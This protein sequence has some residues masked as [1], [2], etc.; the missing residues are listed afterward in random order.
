LVQNSV[1][2]LSDAGVLTGLTGLTSSGSVTLSGLTSGRVPYASTGGLLADSANLLYSGTD[3]TVYGL[4]VGRGA[5]AVSTNTAVGASALAANTSGANNTGIGNNAL[6]SNTTGN[7][8][9]SVGRSALGSITTASDNSALGYFALQSNSTGA[10]NTAVGVSAL[11]ENTTGSNNTAL[12]YQA[13]YTQTTSASGTVIGYQ[14]GYS[15][16]G[17]SLNESVFVGH[18]TGYYQTGG[19]NTAIGHSAFLGSTTPANNTGYYNTSVGIQA[20]KSNT[21]GINNTS[22]GHQALQANT[23]ADYNT[24]VGFQAGY[25]NTT[26]TGNTA[27]GYQAGYTAATNAYN[28]FIGFKAGYSSAVAGNG[29]NTCV[30][31]EVGY[32]LTT[33]TG[34]TFIGGANSASG[35]FVTS[36]SNNTILGGFNGNQDSLDI[37]TVSNYAV[38]SDGAGNRQITM[39]EGQ[40][41][42]LDSA[43]PNAGTG[44][45]FPATQSASSDANTLDDYEE[46]TWTPS[47]GGTA[48]Y[49]TQTATYTKIG[50]LV[51]VSCQFQVNLILTG[52]TTTLSGLPFSGASNAGNTLTVLYWANTANN[53]V[54]INASVG[55]TNLTFFGATS[56]TTTASSYTL[57]G[58]STRI[59]FSGCYYV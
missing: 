57:F 16:T 28:T 13:G 14:A 39:K 43:V 53:V 18:Q 38:I 21:S 46:G 37:R 23:T 44:I 51:F 35:Y 49:T 41:L 59:D 56:G 31:A 26:A 45:T 2:I 54:S 24:A 48:T 8:N 17:N 19:S 12:G 58:N 29:F 9:S 10:N 5:G 3:L 27:I 42:A 50:R 34:N 1:G 11:Q 20:L 33:G 36:G 22:L 40:T 47:L 6:L 52:S 4:T 7:R 25:S 30:G 55:G 15:A 32:S